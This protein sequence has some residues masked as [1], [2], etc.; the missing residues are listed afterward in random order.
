MQQTLRS[1]KVI[2]DVLIIISY[3]IVHSK[4]MIFSTITEVLNVQLE[5]ESESESSDYFSVEFTL[6]NE[7]GSLVSALEVFH[8]SR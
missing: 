6:R 2:V 1:V 8:V 4:N 3:I 7:V 5:T